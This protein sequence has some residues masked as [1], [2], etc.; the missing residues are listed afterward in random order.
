MESTALLIGFVAMSVGSL[1][2]YATGSKSSAI[3]HHTQIHA[4]VPFIAATAY[5]AMYLGTFVMD[6]G[7][8]VTLYLPRYADWIFTTPLLLS[9]LVAL[10]LHEHPRQGG[11]IVA[12]VGLDALMILTGLLS[13]MSLDGSTRLIWFLWS[14]AAF[15]GVYYMIWGPLRERSASYGGALH[16]VYRKNAGQLSVVWL[17]YPVVFALGPEGLGTISA[18]ASVWAILVLDVIAKVAYGFTAGERL[19]KAE[20]ELTSREARRLA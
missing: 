9:G 7:D 16:E 17:I 20:P 1:G 11:Y 13:A 2:I 3:R 14:C 12:I 18:A 19:K 10:A 15:A 5:L 6:R 4:L 8:G